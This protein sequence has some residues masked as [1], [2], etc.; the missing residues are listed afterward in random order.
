VDGNRDDAL[1]EKY[2]VQFMPTLL[3]LDPD[4][5]KVGQMSDRSAAGLKAQFEEIAKKHGRAPA[6]L[7]GAE[8]A[9]GAARDGAK[10]A[11][12]LFVDEKPKSQ[13]FERMFSDPSF[14]VDLYEKAAFAKVAFKKDSDD[15][16]RWKVSE[17]GTLVIV[18]AAGEGKIL[19]TLKSG[20]PK[21][22][23]KEIEDAVKKLSPK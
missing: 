4:G 10:P 16:K 2:G 8:A 19:K 12:L 18:D 14:G 1:F 17:A 7:E 13:V 23:R 22:I 21:S 11:V 20:T 3:F 9:L 15:A 5:K 6:W